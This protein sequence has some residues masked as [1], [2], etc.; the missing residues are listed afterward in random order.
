[1]KPASLISPM[2]PPV[3]AA[4][5]P[6][7]ASPISPPPQDHRAQDNQTSACF[8]VS[9]RAGV[10]PHRRHRRSVEGPLCCILR[11]KISSSICFLC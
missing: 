10:R 9:T 2:T 4:G 5:T 6:S 7:L 1:V 11:E 3:G 8:I